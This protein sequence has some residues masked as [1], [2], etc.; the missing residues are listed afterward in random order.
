LS[1]DFLSGPAQG[2]SYFLHPI[3][4][5][6]FSHSAKSTNQKK[7][8]NTTSLT[9]SSTSPI[10]WPLERRRP[11]SMYHQIQSNTRHIE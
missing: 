2:C 3:Q 1:Q 9:L 10:R 7:L 4:K 6:M 5:K 8:T 11:I